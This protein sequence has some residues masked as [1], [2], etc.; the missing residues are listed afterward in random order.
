MPLDCET[1]H[2]VMIEREILA[3]DNKNVRQ[4][5]SQILYNSEKTLH[6]I[7]AEF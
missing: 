1:L 7:F 5:L 2:K 4:I 3:K 6:Q